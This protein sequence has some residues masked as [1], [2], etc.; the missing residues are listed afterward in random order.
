[1]QSQAT[2]YWYFSIHYKNKHYWIVLQGKKSSINLAFVKC[3]V[4]C[5]NFL[6]VKFTIMDIITLQFVQ[7]ILCKN[8]NLFL[9]K[10]GHKEHK[11]SAQNHLSIYWSNLSAYGTDDWSNLPF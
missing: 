5:L 6:K 4:L 1:M 11:N 3:Q 8:C 9:R 10:T 2:F 7:G